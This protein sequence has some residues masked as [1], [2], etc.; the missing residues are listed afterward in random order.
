MR[1]SYVWTLRVVLAV[2]G[3]ANAAGVYYWPT[4]GSPRTIIHIIISGLVVFVLSCWRPAAPAAPFAEYR[5]TF[6]GSR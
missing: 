4:Y 2:C 5:E 1:R 6:R 3:L